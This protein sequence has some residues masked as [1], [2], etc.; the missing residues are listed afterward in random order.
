MRKKLYNCKTMNIERADKKVCTKKI[1][2]KKKLTFSLEVFPPK[3]DL[4]GEKLNILIEELKKL[5]QYE[6][7]LVSITYGA[8]GMGSKDKTLTCAKK[9]KEELKL[10]CMPHFTCINSTN[11]FVLNYI[12]EIEKLGFDHILALRGDKTKD[13]QVQNDLKSDFQFA[14]DL[15]KF[16]KTNSS[17]N[18]SAAGYPEGHNEAESLN[19]D[20][21]ILKLKTE[22]GASS[23]YTQLFFDNEKFYKYFEKARSLK[24]GTPIIP[25]ILPITSFKQTFKMIEMCNVSI[26][27]QLFQKLEKYQDEKHA[28]FEIGFEHACSQIKGLQDFGVNEAHFYTLNKASSTKNILK[29][30]S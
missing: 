4:D 3:D 27:K 24:I 6:P 18:I 13:E 14:S 29:E 10:N 11:D 20:L 8:G 23:I 16:I 17:I 7:S 19:E 25:G 9:I 1:E 5:K 15:I 12:T 22:L 30:C 21:K 26:P 2:V 28:I